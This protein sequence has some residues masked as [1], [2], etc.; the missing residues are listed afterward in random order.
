MKKQGFDDVPLGAHVKDTVTGF[1]GIVESRTEWLNGCRRIGVLPLGLKDDGSLRDAAN[2][3][4]EQLEVLNKRGVE[5][6]PVS[7][8]T[9]GPMPAPERR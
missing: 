7:R 3:D 2:F 8:R 9:N 5:P 1:E 4:I 6:K